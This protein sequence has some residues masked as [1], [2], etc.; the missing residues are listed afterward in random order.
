MAAPELI[1]NA[2]VNVTG[3]YTFFQYVQ[4]VSSNWFFPSI[5]LGLFI[6]LFVIFRGASTSNSKPFATSS[7]FIM[8]LSILFRVLGFIENKWMYASITIMAFSIL[9]LH[10]SNTKE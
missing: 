7:F 6:I 9:W 8:I 3:M 10:L 1:T 5:L 2:T 4:E